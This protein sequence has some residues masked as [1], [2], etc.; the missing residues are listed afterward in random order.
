MGRAKSSVPAAMTAA[1]RSQQSA[2]FFGSN[3]TDGDAK[4]VVCG[5]SLKFAFLALHAAYET[6]TQCLATY[7][8]RVGRG[9]ALVKRAKCLVRLR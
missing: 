5:E 3:C 1:L 4:K 7:F 2:S 6:Q 8:D 9:E